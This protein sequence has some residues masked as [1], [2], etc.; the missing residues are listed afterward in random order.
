MRQPRDLVYFR[1]GSGKTGGG[2]FV[3]NVKLSDRAFVDGMSKTLA[4][5]EVKAY[6]GK[7]ANSSNPGAVGSRFPI[8]RQP[9]WR[10]VNLWRHRAH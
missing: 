8:R 1:P 4:F 6:Q 5:S 3:V 7:L 10:W 9:S 2:A